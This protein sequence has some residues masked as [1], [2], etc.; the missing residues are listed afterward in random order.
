MQ[1]KTYLQGQ[2]KRLKKNL[3]TCATL[4]VVFYSK[5]LD[6]RRSIAFEL[7]YPFF[8]LCGE[9]NNCFLICV[10]SRFCA[11][12]RQLAANKSIENHN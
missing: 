1:K 4:R 5:N 7:A 6:S 11:L 10:S 12:K 8:L 9:K 2:D 3:H